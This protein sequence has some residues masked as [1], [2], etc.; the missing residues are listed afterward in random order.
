MR[1]PELPPTYLPNSSSS[2]GDESVVGEGTEIGQDAKIL[3]S[4]IGRNCKIGRRLF[5]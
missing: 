1:Y 4:V 2:L 5:Q 3:Q